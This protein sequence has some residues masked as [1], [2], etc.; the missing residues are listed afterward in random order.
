MAKA[1]SVCETCGWEQ[2]SR[3]PEWTRRAGEVHAE[4][5]KPGHLVTFSVDDRG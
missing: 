3:D 1:K 2:E 4:Y 5:L